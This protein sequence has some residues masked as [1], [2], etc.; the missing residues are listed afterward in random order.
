MHAQSRSFRFNRRSVNGIIGTQIVQVNGIPH[1]VKNLS[2]RYK[3]TASGEDNHREDMSSDSDLEIPMFYMMQSDDL[4]PAS[5]ST[6]QTWKY[7]CQ[8]SPLHLYKGVH[9]KAFAPPN[10]LCDHEVRGKF[11]ERDDLPPE[12]HI[13]LACQVSLKN[14]GCH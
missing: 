2:P 12:K 11:D 3:L 13:C 7:C 1:L 8:K 5:E 10:H 6:G 9:L 14:S 4:P